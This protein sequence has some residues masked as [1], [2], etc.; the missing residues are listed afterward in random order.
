MSINM[1]DIVIQ[2]PA[3]EP[4]Q[5]AVCAPILRALPAWFGLEEATAQY[6]RDIEEMPTLLAVAPAGQDVP[7]AQDKVVGFLTLN[8]HTAYAAE[9]HVMGVLP[10]MHRRG[11]GRALVDRAEEVLCGEGIEYL[12]VKT[13]SPRR[14]SED[15][16]RTREFYS[17]LGFRPLQEFPELWGAGN[18]C[19]QMI[20]WLG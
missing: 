12:Q 19:L 6:I 8:Y 16:A 18:P 4:A 3:I 5:A 17:A 2:G 11:V 10:A 15:Y 14:E 9:I 1:E 13:L 20:K 7:G